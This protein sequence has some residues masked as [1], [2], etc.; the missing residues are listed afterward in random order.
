MDIADFAERFAGTKLP[1]WQKEYLRVLY[2]RSRD[3]PIY[4]SIRPH[5]GRDAFYTYFD[6]NILREL[7]QNGTT[8]NS[9]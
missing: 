2:E 4:I 5:Q 9:H 7:T 8:S 3:T 1:E 6:R